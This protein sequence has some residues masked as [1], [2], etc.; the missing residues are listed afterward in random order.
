M[1]V[2]NDA[3]RWMYVALLLA[4]VVIG[5]TFFMFYAGTTSGVE[6]REL[7][8]RVKTLEERIETLNTLL[9]NIRYLNRTVVDLLPAL[10][11]LTK[12]SIVRIENRVGSGATMRVNSI[13]SGFV[14]SSDGYIVTNNHVVEGAS[15]LVV[16][17]LNG[18]SSK[19][20]IVGTDPYSDLAV[21]KLDRK[22]P[23]LKPL[24][25][26]RSSTLQV[27][28]T[29]VAIGSPFGLSNTMTAG[30]VSQVGR[31]IDAPGGY[32]IFDVIQHDVAINP[33]NS[34]G[35]LINLRGEVV[36]LNT[37]II[38]ASGTS[39]GVG[40]AIPSDTVARE[41]PYLIATG[42]YKHPYLGIRGV[43]VNSDIAE[44]AKLNI[45]WGFLV[46]EVVPGG[47]ADKAGL[48]GG[49]TD[50]VVLGQTI[51]VGGD[52]IV[53]VDGNQVKRLDDLSVYVERN[54]RPGDLVALTIIRDGKK[55]SIMLT[56]G[57]RP[58]LS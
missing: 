27:G 25:L 54:K 58:P 41:V 47:P 43:N 11:N 5:N 32:S 56:L 39:S 22:I 40:F 20:R 19:A 7:L 55:L 49:R 21:I 8:T 42:T 53:G 12:D 52:L 4:L 9:E 13:G 24:P 15:E 16:V 51:R 46:T 30:I 36:G 17:F 50:R 44:A 18:N 45:T 48:R 3:K 31:D 28:E 14:Y 1:Y 35:P 57:E 6:R 29:V 23:G 33:G 34:G 38:S 37:A 2:E 10:Y 26:G